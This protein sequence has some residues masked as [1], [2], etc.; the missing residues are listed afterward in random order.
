M[1]RIQSPTCFDNRT[2]FY[3]AVVLTLLLVMAGCGGGGGGEPKTTVTLYALADDGTENSPISKAVC[4]F[5]DMD[6]LPRAQAIADDSGEF[7]IELSP[8]TEGYLRCYPP[9]IPR[10]I[11]STFV[12]TKGLQG[13]DTISEIIT[14]N[15]TVITNIIISENAM[16][17]LARK[18]ELEHLIQTEQ[19][20]DLNLV[21]NFSTLLYKSMLKRRINVDFGGGG[22]GGGGEGG[23]GGGVG[24][25]GGDGAAASPIAN[26]RCQ[27]IVGNDLIKGN[28]LYSAAISDFVDD[29]EI[30]RLDLKKALPDLEALLQNHSPE[31][32]QLA[33]QAFFKDGIGQAYVAETDEEG[34]YF[35]DSPPDVPGFVRCFP[36][37]QE[38]LVLATYVPARSEGE[39]LLNQDVNP[40]TTYF[41]HKIASKLSDD[42]SIVKE[43]YLNDIAGLGDIRIV[44]SG[45]KITGFEIDPADDPADHDVGLVAFSATSLFNVLYKNNVKTVDYLAAL[46]DFVDKKSIDP[47]FLSTSGVPPA[48]ATELADVANTSNQEAG[49]DLGTDLGSALSKGRIHVTVTGTA[50]G[51]GISNA[52]VDITNAPSGVECNCVLPMT[53]DAGQ[54]ELE[55]IGLSDEAANVTVEVSGVA[56]FLPTEKTVSVVASA[57]VDLDISLDSDCSYIISPP[58]RNF[59]A[60]AGSGTI[61]V[62][63]LSADCSWTATE[64]AGWITITSGSSGSG[65]GTVT[66]SVTAN[67]G[68]QRSATITV[69]GKRH[70]VTQEAGSCTYSI[71]P[72]TRTVSASA[73]SYTIDV[74]ALR[75][76]CSWTASDSA[77]WITIASGSSSGTGDGMVTYSVTA[78][79]GAQRTATITVAGRS[80]TVTQQA[81]LPL[82]TYTIS[83]ATRTV[84]ASAGSYTVSVDA[85][86]ADCSWTASESAGWI[87]IAS[88]SSSGT[89]DGMVTYSVTANTGA[90]RTATITVA[91]RSHTVT[92][93]APLP[94]CT[95]TISPAARTVSASAGSY[96]V[97]VDALRA[98]CSWTASESAGW[99]TI[100]SGS[101]GSGDGTVTYSVTANTG[102]QRSATITVEG[103]RHTVTQEAGSCTYSILPATRTV[104]A[105]AGSY[106]VSVDALRADCSWTATES[107]GWITITAG[108]NG[109]GDGTVTYRVTANAGSQRS[110]TITV[111]GRSHVVT[112][113]PVYSCGT[114]QIDGGNAADTRQIEMGSTSGTFDFTYQTYSIRDRMIVRY[115]NSVLFDTGCVGASGTVPLTFSGTSSQ[116]SVEVIPNCAGTTGTDWYY[117]VDCLQA[118][119]ISGLV[120][121]FPFSDNLQDESGNN[122]D[123]SVLVGNPTVNNGVLTL[124]GSSI[125]SVGSPNLFNNINNYTIMAWVWYSWDGYP[126]SSA[127]YQTIF[128]R[129]GSFYMNIRQDTRKIVVGFRT[130]ENCS[131]GIIKKVWESS[132]QV[133]EGVWTHVAATFNYNT[134]SAKIYINGNSVGITA[135]TP[136]CNTNQYELYPVGLGGRY[137]NAADC[138]TC[139]DIF[140]NGYL[141]DVRI[142][143]RVLGQSEINQLR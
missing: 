25:D 29:G 40:A 30:S 96:T 20:K 82:C 2:V 136:H 48:Q 71:S 33:F 128:E 135:R 8:D 34:K 110:A 56:G 81:P 130:D 62:D 122:R 18:I 78:N 120:A 86:R 37:E 126:T 129:H 54:V 69:E 32:I 100:T 49:D 127:W 21:T 46:D 75:T 94:L 108:S 123:A 59:A 98:D 91:G 143:S 101:S 102:D 141:D 105:S 35:I 142:Y 70:T 115:Q 22:G 107:A 41:S 23:G 1:Q 79:T 93:Q 15:T 92:Q 121:Y 85:L 74:D 114:D 19:D 14:P 77:G 90:Q 67:T 51:T 9:D 10:L 112:Q 53:I 66:Y 26:A 57:K 72:A 80:H 42:V 7:S 118:P 65:D 133:Q 58:S 16:V 45:G 76:D 117:K 61:S 39:E 31:K 4:E 131:N 43:N 132:P 134:Q 109:S 119:P 140:F 137:A 95:Y 88:G 73:G 12:S 87:T 124:N 52:V 11:L 125:L 138:P 99:I 28:V 104:S 47:V 50:G 38:N 64:S 60:S 97:S 6:G 36:P 106:T 5:R 103:K 83:P 89:G 17:P 68:D 44:E 27:F 84:S 13:G 3:V 111:A 24:G 55:L 116:I 139:P 113:N 63:A